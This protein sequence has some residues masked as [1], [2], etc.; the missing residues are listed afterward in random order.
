MHIT[1]E[2]IIVEIVDC[3][4]RVLPPGHE[5]EVVITHLATRDFPFIR[6][7]TGDVAVLDD[8]P[9]SCGRGL[10]LIKEI[11][12]RSTDFVV[13]SDGTVMHGLA[14]IYVIRDIQGVENF[15]IV[16]KSLQN[17]QVYLVT[18]ELFAEENVAV[19]ENGLKRRLGPDVSVAI[20]RVPQIPRESSGKHRY[21]V[22]HVQAGSH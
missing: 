15:K 3:D 4:G 19:I 2:D 11:Q 20:E 21:V 16:Q 14:L 9:C 1:A 12:G 18:N 22:S 6:Y 10:P 7:R 8:K 13:A 17:T 5:G